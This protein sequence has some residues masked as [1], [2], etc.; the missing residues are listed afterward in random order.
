MSVNSRG[1]RPTQAAEKLGIGVS[2]LWLRAKRDADFPKPVKLSTR[3]TIFI[4][5]ELD[6]YLQK[7]VAESRGMVAA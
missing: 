6:A 5:A 1:L 7:R 2:T 4:E 3:T